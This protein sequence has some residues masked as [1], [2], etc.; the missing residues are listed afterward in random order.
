MGIY[1]CLN[2][3]WIFKPTNTWNVAFYDAL[4]SLRPINESAL[5]IPATFSFYENNARRLC[6]SIIFSRRWTTQLLK[7]SVT[8]W[9]GVCSRSKGEYRLLSFLHAAWIN[10]QQMSEN[11]K[12]P[13]SFKMQLHIWLI[14]LI[15]TF[16]MGRIISF[17]FYGK[18]GIDSAIRYYL[19]GSRNQIYKCV[20]VHILFWEAN[21][22]LTHGL[23][24]NRKFVFITPRKTKQPR[25]CFFH[26]YS[27]YTVLLFQY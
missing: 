21:L 9:N 24:Y 18:T 4:V 11:Y 10:C 20:A 12:I 7:H 26:S 27:L 16:C 25:R 5:I 22:L 2:F 17:A 3:C 19:Y 23:L 14:S 13:I 6:Q 8:S 1:R 15:I